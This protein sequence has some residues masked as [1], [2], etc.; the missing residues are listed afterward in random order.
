MGGPGCPVKVTLAIIYAEGDALLAVCRRAVQMHLLLTLF[1]ERGESDTALC[2]HLD[3][4]N[5]LS[6]SF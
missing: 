3:Y 6:F 4:R 5:V 2:K 1:R